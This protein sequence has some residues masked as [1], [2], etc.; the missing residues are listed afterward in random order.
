MASTMPLEHP[1]SN[2]VDEVFDRIFAL[3]DTFEKALGDVRRILTQPETEKSDATKTL[4]EAVAAGL[5]KCM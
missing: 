4:K 2:N 3:R 5:A 1:E